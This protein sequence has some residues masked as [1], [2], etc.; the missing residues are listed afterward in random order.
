MADSKQEN[1]GNGS[2]E[3]VALELYLECNRRSGD[4]P[5]TKEAVLELYKECLMAVQ[6]PYS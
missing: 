5:D 3:R 2:P 4:S 1:Y 6:T